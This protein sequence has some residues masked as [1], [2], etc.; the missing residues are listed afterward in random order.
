MPSIGFLLHPGFSPMSLGMAAAFDTANQHAGRKVYDLIMLSE[1]GGLVRGAMGLSVATEALSR[2]HLDLIVVGGGVEAT[3]AAT[4][5][6]LKKALG[7]VSRI[8]ATCT[9]TFVLAEAGLLDGR[10]AT[11]HWARARELQRRFPKVKVEE[12]RIFVEDGPIWT[13]AGMTAGLDLALAFIERDLGTEAARSVARTLVMY[14]RRTGGQ[15]QFSALLELEPK[16]D[17]IQKVLTYAR[18][19]LDNRL[20][21]EELADI[22]GLGARQFNRVFLKETG[23]SPA[24]AIETL[25]LEAA[26]SLMEETGQTID[27]VAQQTG[28][29]DRDRMRRAFVRAFGQPPQTIRR[30]T[31][32]SSPQA[33]ASPTPRIAQKS[34]ATVS[35]RGTVR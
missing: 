9:A 23:Q 25:R 31:R 30:A 34:R 6:F 18:R 13:S 19:H 33:D 5:T 2:R 10:R 20:S 21:V 12:D 1:A 35:R 32:A 8:A 29:A 24:K 26:R 4:I 16:S 3:T 15:S 7:R 17:R 28:F 14:H 22:A 11:T 27:A